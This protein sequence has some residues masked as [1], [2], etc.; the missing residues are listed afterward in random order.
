[1]TSLVALTRSP[2]NSRSQSVRTEFSN[3]TPLQSFAQSP[4]RGETAA[5]TVALDRRTRSTADVH[6]SSPASSS[7]RSCR[8][9]STA[10]AR[11]SAGADALGVTAGRRGR[12]PPCSL[13]RRRHGRDRRRRGRRGA[14]RHP[15]RRGL[16]GLDPAP[17]QPRRL[18]C[19][20]RVR[21]RGGDDRDVAVWDSL[22]LALHEGW[23]VVDDGLTSSAVTARRSTSAAR[24]PGT[25]TRPI[26]S[27]AR[28]ATST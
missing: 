18:R 28:R 12:G 21:F 14:G 3:A 2:R 6:R 16:L 9:S 15:R 10:T 22:W 11:W 19:D 1:M 23:P 24:S 4:V 27:S 20:E 25:T 5:M 26:T 17:A 8:R 7:R 13:V